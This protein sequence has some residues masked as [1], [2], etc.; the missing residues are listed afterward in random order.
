ML[1]TSKVLI[2]SSIRHCSTWRI[3]LIY[4]LV[5]INAYTGVN[6]CLKNFLMLLDYQKDGFDLQ[7]DDGDLWCYPFLSAL[8]GDLPEDA[9]LTLTF[10]SA[11]CKYPCHKCLIDADEMNNT[12]LE[13]SQIILRTPENMKA[14]I[15]EDIA[16]QYSLFS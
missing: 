6:Q 12:N 2:N 3:M 8:L 5:L 10:N 4:D 9:A 16:D 7:T 13:S 1:F 11:N 15:Y 14:A